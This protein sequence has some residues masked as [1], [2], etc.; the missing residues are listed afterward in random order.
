MMIAKL[1]FRNII[2]NKLRTAAILLTVA[3]S[4]VMLFLGLIYNR[5][6]V[7]QFMETKVVESENADLRLA[8][9]AGSSSRVITAEHLSQFDSEI[10]FAAGV[11]ELYGSAALDGQQV[12]I[13][14]RGATEENI[15][16]LNNLTYIA[17]QNRAMRK[18]ELVISQKTAEEYGLKINSTFMIAVGS[19]Q[20]L[21]TVGKIA[22]HHACFD[23]PGAIVMYGIESFV[24]SYFWGGGFGKVYNKIYIKTVDGVN[25]DDLGKRIMEIEAYKGYDIKETSQDEELRRRANEIAIPVTIAVLGCLLLGLL[26]VYM[27]FNAGV[28]KRAELISRLK[29]VGAK[30]SFIS[31]IFM[32]ECFIYIVIGA[33]LGYLCNKFLFKHYLPKIISFDTADIFY[34]NVMIYSSAATAAT[35]FIMSLLP[36]IKTRGVAIRTSF[37]AAKNTVWK[38]NLIVFLLGM[39]MIVTAA[40]LCIPYRLEANRGIASLLLGILG[41]LLVAPYAARYFVKGLQKVFHWG[42]ANL[43]LKN[44]ESERGLAN[45]LRVLTAGMMICI[46]I[47]SAANITYNLGLQTVENIDSD[48]I[49]ENIR[50]QS[51]TP[52]NTIKSIEGVYDVYAYQMRKVDIVAAGE[53]TE[54]N[55]IGISPDNLGFIKDTGSVSSREEIISMIAKKEG[56][57]IDISYSKVFGIAIGDKINITIGGI[58]Q[59]I[60]VVGFFQSYFYAVGKTAVMSNELMSELFGLPLFDSLVCKTTEDVE[61]TIA[62]IRA[63][64]GTYNIIAYNKG[65]AYGVYLTVLQNLVDFSNIFTYFVILVCIFGILTNILNSREERKGVFYQLYSLGV[66]RM[67]LFLCELLESVFVLIVT[68]GLTAAALALCNYALINTIAIMQIYVMRAINTKIALTIS[69]IFGAFYL[70]LSINSFFTINKK[71]L[72]GA[73]KTY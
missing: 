59:D 15:D 28:K 57:L 24:S 44:V 2:K 39:A 10:E 21:F 1:T 8:Y 73:I 51:P 11:L 72:I 27:V 25:Q 58:T 30:N 37:S 50:A 19:K 71:Q 45:T 18:H 34:R 67:Q 70:L 16:K 42:A 26:L 33:G 36:I 6:A 4:C 55:L 62:K 7:G 40:C 20:Q 60:A 22:Q 63:G 32:M 66:S 29:S 23:A 69:A 53:K 38:S 41:I 17:Q 48:I 3:L 31:T 61:E 65:A 47:S 35:V 49:I 52:I 43:A 64:L 12:Y 9:T 5:L 46:I 13:N 54:I 14:L 68:F 56:M